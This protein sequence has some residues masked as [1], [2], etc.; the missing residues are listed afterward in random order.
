M[1]G[2]EANPIIWSRLADEVVPLATS[3]RITT[4][5]RF[6]ARQRD[7]S[8]PAPMLEVNLVK[9]RAA[10]GPMRPPLAECWNHRLMIRNYGELEELRYLLEVDDAAREAANTEQDGSGRVAEVSGTAEVGE[11]EGAGTEDEDGQAAL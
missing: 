3:W 11:R 2:D 10:S 5:D 1:G 4:S 6:R 7:G 8:D 9:Y